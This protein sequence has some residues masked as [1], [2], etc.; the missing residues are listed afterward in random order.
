MVSQKKI[1]NPNQ[2]GSGFVVGIVALIAIVAVIIGVVLYMGRNQ[3]IEGLPNEDVAFGVEY[4]GDIMRLASD[5]AGDDAVVAEVYED[6]S[7]S[8]CAEMSTGGHDDQLE[9]LNNGDLVVEYRS[10]NFLDESGEGHSTKA[11]AIMERIAQTGDARLFWNFHTLLMEEQQDAIRWENEE[12]AERLEMMEAPGD[13]VEDVR[14]DALAMGEANDTGKANG[15]KL[16][17]IIGSISSPHVIVDGEDVIENAD[18]LD[19]W[20]NAALDAGRS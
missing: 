7:C 13:L 17:G 19:Q 14:N 9:A 8:F 18:G 12:F 1:K 4:D 16:N 5:D 20:V 10:L 11:I 3:P 2:K 15:E 6:Y